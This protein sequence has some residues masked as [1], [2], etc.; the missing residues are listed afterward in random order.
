LLQ[1]RN[2][3]FSLAQGCGPVIRERHWGAPGW[4]ESMNNKHANLLA[5]ALDYGE[6]AIFIFATITNSRWCC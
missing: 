3:N 5:Y 2:D 4:K 1:I 6:G